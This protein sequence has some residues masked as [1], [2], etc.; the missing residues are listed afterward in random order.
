MFGKKKN[1]PH[2]KLPFNQQKKIAQAYIE[3]RRKTPG[4]SWPDFLK[5]KQEEK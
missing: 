1:K 3:E 2:E 5:K 4:L